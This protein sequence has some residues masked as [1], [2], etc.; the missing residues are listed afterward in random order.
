MMQAQLG[1]VQL[2]KAKLEIVKREL[3]QFSPT[4]LKIELFQFESIR[5]NKVD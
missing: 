5:S 4:Q 1:V 3:G 2:K